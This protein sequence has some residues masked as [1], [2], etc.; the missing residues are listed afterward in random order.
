VNFQIITLNYGNYSVV[1]E[2]ED[3]LDSLH[4]ETS[5]HFAVSCYTSNS[6]PSPSTSNY[7]T[8][9]IFSLLEITRIPQKL[10]LCWSSVLYEEK[11]QSRKAKRV[12][13]AV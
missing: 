1:V 9:A 10:P 7:P 5:H 8:F 12:P 11:L 3:C 13:Q 4:F 2:G 6:N